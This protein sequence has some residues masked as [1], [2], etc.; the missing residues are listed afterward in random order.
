MIA[1]HFS[2]ERQ[3]LF[4]LNEF[5]T[6]FKLDFFVVTEKPHQGSVNKVLYCIVLYCFLCHIKKTE[7]IVQGSLHSLHGRDT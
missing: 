1:L 3:V 2:K 4:I 6:S 5:S 7:T